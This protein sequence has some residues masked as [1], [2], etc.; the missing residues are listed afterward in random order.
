MVQAERGMQE[1]L[2]SVDT[3]IVIPNEKLLAVA[4]DAGF[5]Q[6][7]RVADDVLR[8][9]VQGISDI[10]TIPGII[11][12]DFADVKTT[13]AGMGYAVMGTA[14]RAGSNRAIEAAQAAMASPLLEAGAIDG[15]RGILINITGSASLKLSE[16]NEA[17]TLI[18][19]SAHEDANIIFGAVLDETMA[20]E[21]KITVIATGF[22]QGSPERRE[23]MLSAPCA[24]KPS[25]P[26]SRRAHPRRA[27]PARKPKRP[28][29]ASSFAAYP[30]PGFLPRIRLRLPGSRFRSRHHRS[31]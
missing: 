5:F 10:I 11:N 7:F 16:V 12:R 17:S 2:E 13:M 23:Q 27:S 15:A 4:K 25:R 8:Q 30:G 29:L 26:G 6:S 22:R 18:Q 28:S 3:M 21:V 9:G 31:R 1:L 19:S 24:R 20:E 14:V